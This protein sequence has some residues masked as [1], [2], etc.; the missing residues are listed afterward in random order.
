M[1]HLAMRQHNATSTLDVL[2]RRSP[3]TMAD[4]QAELRL[5]R[6][7]LEL[8]LDDLMRA[9]WVDE[10][11][12]AAGGPRPKGRP[13]R[14]FAFRYDAG[15]LL[16]VQLDAGATT[17]TLTDL[18]ADEVRVSHEAM[19]IETS[20]EDRLASLRRLV[21]GLL[22][23]AGVDRSD[24][25]AA[26]VS[27]PGI[28]HDDG[29]VDLP[30]TMPGWTGFSLAAV[31]AEHVD[32]P[33]TV[34]ND[35]KLAALGEKW[36][37]EDGIEN[38]AYLFSDGDRIG[39][40]LVLGG[41]LY[42]GV[43]GNAGEIS[44]APA[45]GISHVH[46]PLLHGLPDESGADHDTAAA[47][48]DAA[49][50]GDPGALAEVGRVAQALAPAITTLSWVLAPEEVVLGG[51]LGLVQ[52][53]LL[54]ALDEVLARNDRPLRTRVVGSRFGERA[55]LAGCLQMCVETLR[56]GFAEGAETRPG[57]Q[58]VEQEA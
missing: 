47:L 7:T 1:D 32:C 22:A 11:F 10:V 19:P 29:T 31:L 55:V 13:A 18:A 14:V 23:S 52:D 6:R 34:E 16:A 41:E 42:R 53:L 24:V 54:P 51:T 49:R 40:G 17:V 56:A 36:S 30:F 57:D 26:T 8:I 12:P 33:V 48:V 38:F 15:S 21:T 9:G 58:V 3:A 44:W 25:L 4:L 46:S 43:D 27:T 50:A 5:S 35:A 45:L 20:R 39:L 28:V 37:R 2:Y